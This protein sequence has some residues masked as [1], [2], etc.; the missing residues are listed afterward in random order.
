MLMRPFL[1]LA[2]LVI[3]G[4]VP[5]AR[6]DTPAKKPSPAATPEQLVEQLAS[7]DPQVREKAG[8]ALAALGKEALPALL[9]AKG[10]ADPEMRRRLDE[11]I[12]PLERAALLTARPLTLHI[13]NKPIREILAELSRQSGYKLNYG[14]EGQQVSPT[15]RDKVVYTFHFD[16]LPFWQALDKITEATGMVPQQGNYYDSDAMYFYPND[17][18]VPFSCYNGAFKVVASGFSYSRSNNFGQV[19]KNPTHVNQPAQEF[20]SVSLQVASEPRLPILSVGQIRLTAAIDDEGHS[21]L[22]AS[23]NAPVNPYGNRYYGGPWGY[24]YM[25][26]TQANLHWVSR[27]AK[28]VKTLKGII[29]VTLL[30]DQKPTVVT[31]KILACKGKKLKAGDATFHIEEI[32]GTP[33]KPYQIKMTVTEEN[34]ENPNDYSRIQSIQQRIGLQDNKG[35]KL[36]CF[37]NITNWGGPNNIQFTLMMQPTNNAKL[38]AQQDDLLRVGPY[39]A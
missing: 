9:K 37:C 38:G 36:P 17:S 10:S 34:K 21:M 20:L 13:T 27:T 14:W 32:T 19:P 33:G 4:F 22:D 39:A 31:D 18:Y 26:G 3:L 5:W 12:P 35:N 28:T 16:K 2:V 11:M 7:R 24:S 1:C 15:F 23:N 6:S 25:Q 30:A 8:K 29:P